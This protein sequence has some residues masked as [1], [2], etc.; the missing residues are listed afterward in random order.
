MRFINNT[1]G[2]ILIQTKVTGSRLSVDIYGTNDGRKVLIEG[3]V[4]YDKK[5]SG[6]LKAYFVRKI[7][8]EDRLVKEERFDSVYKAPPPHEVNPL[9]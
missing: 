8:N 2:H 9:E 7:Y 3:P 5:P 4:Q 1:G 6:A